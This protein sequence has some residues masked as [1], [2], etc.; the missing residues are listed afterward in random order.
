[1]SRIRLEQEWRPVNTVYCIGRNYVAHI[2]ELGNEMPA[3]PLVFLKP[4]ACL[5]NGGAEIVLP[6]FSENVHYET[7]LVLLIGEDA[8]SLSEENALSAVA[9]Y[10]VGLDL[11]ARDVQDEIKAKGLPWTKAKGFKG[12]ACVSDFIA[13]D[14]LTRPLQTA[15]GLR[16]NG[17]TRQSGDTALMM[18]PLPKILCFLAETYGLRRGDLVFTGT[19]EGVGKLNAG[20]VLQLDLAGLVQAGFTV[21]A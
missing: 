21:A 19:P 3:E 1:M 2:A 12:A 16:V 7:E 14:K 11:T 13:A 10:G 8:D 9:G 6:P 20:D 15:F 4:N 5:L 17:A 18:F